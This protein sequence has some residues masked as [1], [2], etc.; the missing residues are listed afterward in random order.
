MMACS[1]PQV[2]LT[3]IFRPSNT[4]LHLSV[5]QRLIME[6]WLFCSCIA[7]A[8][9]LMRPEAAHLLDT[10]HLLCGMQTEPDTGTDVRSS[11]HQPWL[12]CPFTFIRFSPASRPIS[13]IEER[14]YTC[15]RLGI[16]NAKEEHGILS[17]L[18]IP[19][20]LSN[21]LGYHSQMQRL[22]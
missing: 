14:S 11:P 8:A 1:V 15:S 20:F 3:T 19:P 12:A 17:Y 7:V 10:P 18:E 9:L 4:P 5:K 6:Y 21:L 13:S 16:F 2:S 22:P